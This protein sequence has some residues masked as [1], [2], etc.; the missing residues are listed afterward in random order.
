MI[1]Q[2]HII[3]F[4]VAVL[5]AVTMFAAELGFDSFT[6][7]SDGKDITVEWRTSNEKAVARF[8]IERSTDGQS[9]RTVGTLEARGGNQSYRFVDVDVL[10]K[11]NDDPKSIVRNNFQY[12]IRAIG[13]D[14]TSTY[15]NTSTVMHSI[16]SVRRTWGMIK[17]M[18]K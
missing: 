18:F 7:K 5:C 15:S 4:F 16:S 9:W 3:R 1:I 10:L 2:R 13:S 12:R 11:G 14:N 17:E 8:D 6:A